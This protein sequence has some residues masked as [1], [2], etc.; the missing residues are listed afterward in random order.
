MKRERNFIT[1]ELKLE[2]TRA[3]KALMKCGTTSSEIASPFIASSNLFT[4][5][6]NGQNMSWFTVENDL[7]IRISLLLLKSRYLLSTA[8][9]TN[10]L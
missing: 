1:S 3:S 4:I 7:R 2:F 8:N 5:P 6:T 10:C 9:L